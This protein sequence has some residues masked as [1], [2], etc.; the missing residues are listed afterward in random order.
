LAPIPAGEMT[1]GQLD[2]RIRELEA[3]LADRQHELRE[4]RRLRRPK[5]AAARSAA[6]R[7]AKKE[8]KYERIR[9]EAARHT[10]R[11]RGWRSRLALKCK[12]PEST[13]NRALRSASKS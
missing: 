12:V 10:S 13:A 7:S 8:A 11:E 6:I 4:L 2:V 3:E 5:A 1:L 9:A